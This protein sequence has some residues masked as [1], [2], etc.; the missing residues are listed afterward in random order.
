[1]INYKSFK[2]ANDAKLRVRTENIVATV[3]SKSS[4]SIDLYVAGLDRA[5][6]VPVSDS[7]GASKLI[8]YIWERSEIENKEN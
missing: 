3:S 5:L 7:A 1:M 4:N 8:D 2:V 6:H